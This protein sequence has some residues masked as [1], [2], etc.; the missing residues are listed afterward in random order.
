VIWLETYIYVGS[1]QPL[2]L[3]DEAIAVFFFDGIY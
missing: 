3:N 1:A 2:L